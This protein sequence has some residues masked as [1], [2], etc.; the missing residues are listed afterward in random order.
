MKTCRKE[1]FWIKGQTLIEILVSLGIIT[2][3]ATALTAVV[4]TSM[5]S[6][7][8]SKNKNLASQYAQEGMEIIRQKRDNDYV[9][10]RSLTGVYCLA[11][12]S[13][14]LTQPCNAAANIEG[15]FFRKVTIIQSVC[16]VNPVTNAASVEVEVSWQDGKCTA[17]NAFCHNAKLAS[18]FSTINPVPAL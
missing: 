18:C 1:L 3:L 6:A 14:S 13:T 4:I 2:I 17:G 12:D 16:G 8:F 15:I 11:G 5:D 9:A 10:F 7:Q